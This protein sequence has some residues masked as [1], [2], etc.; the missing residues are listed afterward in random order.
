MPT[1]AAFPQMLERNRRREGLRV[2]RA[3]WLPG[4]SI[5]EHRQLEAGEGTGPGHLGAHVR[6]I[7][8]ASELP[9]S[10]EVALGF[11][12]L[13]WLSID[14]SPTSRCGVRLTDH[15]AS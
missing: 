12:A 10:F 14:E 7:R 13:A 11:F 15:I 4:V 2:C 5:R 1:L 9:A 6:G 8:L 3:A